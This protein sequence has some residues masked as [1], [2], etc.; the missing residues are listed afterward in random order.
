MNFDVRLSTR[1]I[2]DRPNAVTKLALRDRLARVDREFEVL[3]YWLK[4]SVFLL[5][6]IAPRHAY[7]RCYVLNRVGKLIQP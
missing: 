7:A 5:L 1:S 6:T 2:R 4:I 3:K